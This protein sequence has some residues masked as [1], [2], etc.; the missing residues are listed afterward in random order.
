M[1]FHSKTT[2]SVLVLSVSLLA[3]PAFAADG[4]VDGS[5]ASADASVNRDAP[6]TLPATASPKPIPTIDPASLSR[7]IGGMDADAAIASMT[8]VTMNHDGTTAETP[9]PEGLR[10]II[11]ADVKGAPPH[12]SPSAPPTPPTPSP[13]TPPTP[14]PPTP[15]TPSPQPPTPPAPVVPPSAPVQVTDTS[16]NPYINVGWIWAQKQDGNW[17][18]CT[19]TQIGPKTVITSADCVYDHATGGWVKALIWYPGMTDGKT[20]PYGQFDWANM[21]ILKGFIDNYDGAN[22]S[23]V[24]TW[25]LA[26]IELKDDATNLGWLGFKIDDA[27]DFSANLLGYPD[28]APVPGSQWKSTCTVPAAN[29]GDVLFVHD[30]VTAAG[31]GGAAMYTDDG[32]G[33]LIVRGIQVGDSADGKTHFGLRLIDSYFQFLQDNYK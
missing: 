2:I 31:D 21:N 33:N 20:A 16:T 10:A 6:L 28:N 32:K 24:V 9:A 12:A 19:G 11:A 7:G 27:S 8:V 17:W 1:Q 30:C 15:P 26:E 18:T 3:G 13:P 29:F 14:S 22:F 25:D 5:K 4:A 23:S